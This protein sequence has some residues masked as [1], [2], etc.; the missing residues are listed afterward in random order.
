MPGI[1]EK[2]KRNLSIELSKEMKNFNLYVDFVMEMR[3]LKRALC[4][5]VSEG[6]TGK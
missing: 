4:E 6:N 2:W 3:K 5:L 1:T